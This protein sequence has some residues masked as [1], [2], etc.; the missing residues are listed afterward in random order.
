MDEKMVFYWSD[1]VGTLG[2]ENGVLVHKND[3]ATLY[4][5]NIYFFQ[6]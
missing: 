2:N 4:S 6:K 3:L 1:I 5:I